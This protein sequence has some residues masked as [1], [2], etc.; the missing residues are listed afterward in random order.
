[1]TRKTAESESTMLAVKS[2]VVPNDSEIP[3]KAPPLYLSV[4]TR[5]REKIIQKDIRDGAVIKEGPLASVFGISRAPVRRAL[6]MLEQEEILKPANGQGFIVGNRSAGAV[7]S[8][9]DLR[10][11]FLNPSEEGVGRTAAWEGIF[12][13]IYIDVTNCL[14]FGTYQISESV[15]C[16]HFSI[17][18]TAL[19]EA[20]G[21]LQEQGLLEKSAGSPWIAWPLT[22]RDVH[23]AFEVR[24]LL[25]PAAFVRSIA[26]VEKST[27][28]AMRANV[29]MVLKNLDDALPED[30]EKIENDLHQ[31]LLK[32]T[33]N[34]RLLEAI[35]RN[36]FP[37]IV[38]K[39]FRRNF[40]LKPD[41]TA[42][43]DHA[44]IFCQLLKGQIDVACLMLEAH[45]EKAEIGTLAKLRVLSTLPKP[46]TAPYLINKH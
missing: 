12:D 17:G 4:H 37:F 34:K 5:L 30:V 44:E 35:D 45:L 3:K 11:V 33:R 6:Q 25:E 1:M 32:N 18:R 10:L 9:K 40:G 31:V 36:Q 28:R 23:E 26:E 46:A 21:K 2:T 20:L 15:A 43:E 29:D 14:P 8:S 7:L 16:E 42:L 41:Q 38:N 27:I 24:R 39:V 13:S 22:A 19:R